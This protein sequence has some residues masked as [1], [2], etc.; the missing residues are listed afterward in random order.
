MKRTGSIQRK[1]P[2][3]NRSELKGRKPMNR[4]RKPRRQAANDSAWRSETYLAWVRRQ[5][6]VC[7]TGP[8]G[9]AHHVIGLHWG[10]SG[11][12]TTAPDSY[13]MPVC[14]ACHQRIH[15]S[16]EL[17]LSQPAWLRQ[18]IGRATKEF[19]GEVLVELGRAWHFIADKEVA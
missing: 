4:S 8:G 15:A 1:T 5:S 19:D 17:Q 3:K 2:L 16:P 13:V 11:M 14:R 9:D 18:T 12:G 7:C 10:L 6:C